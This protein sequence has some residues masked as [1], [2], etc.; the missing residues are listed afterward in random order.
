MKGNRTSL[1]RSIDKAKRAFDVSVRRYSPLPIALL[2]WCGI[3]FSAGL[4]WLCDWGKSSDEAETLA[5]VAENELDEAKVNLQMAQTEVVRAREI[6]NQ[7]IVR[8]PIDGVVMARTL[9]PGEY[10]FDQSPSRKSIHST[11]RSMSP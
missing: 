11:S 6:L 5:R 8:S 2:T 1:L 4:D 10:A 9:G 7:R 3:D